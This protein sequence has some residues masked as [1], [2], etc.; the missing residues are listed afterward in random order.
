MTDLEGLAYF[1]D[2]NLDGKLNS[3]DPLWGDLK[4][5][6]DQNLNGVT[7]ANELR[8][9]SDYGIVDINLSFS[10]PNFNQDL[11]SNGGGIV[12][13]TVTSRKADGS[14][15]T[16]GDVVLGYA[17][18]NTGSDETRNFV[19]GTSS[20][21]VI[22]GS[23]H[24]DTLYGE[25]GND[26]LCGL[27]GNDTLMGG[28]GNDG[29]IGGGG[30]DALY[31]IN[32]NDTLIGED[33]NDTMM[34]GSDQDFLAGGDGNDS[35]I[36]D[37]GFDTLVGGIGDDVLFG[38]GHHDILSGEDGN[39]TLVGGWG[40]DTLFGGNHNDVLYGEDGYD[41]MD[42][43]TGDDNLFGGN[44]ND[45]L[46]GN[47]GNDT[48]SGEEG[49]D[50]LH[51]NDGNDVLYGNN[52]SDWLT[53]GAGADWLDGGNGA[54]YVNYNG[55]WGAVAVSLEAG[56]G[57]GAEAEG[58]R[59]FNIE[60]IQGSKFNDDLSGSGNSDSIWGG[61]G[62]DWLL[63][64][65]GADALD[66][67]DGYDVANYVESW[68]GVIIDLGAGTGTGGSAEGDRLYNIEGVHGSMYDD[69]LHGNAGSN[70]LF[71]AWGND[72]LHGHDGGDSLYGDLGD[73]FLNGGSGAD[74]LD[75]GEGY[76][77]ATY[78]WAYSGVGVSLDSGS[79][80]MGEATGDVY[81][82]IEG[83]VGSEHADGIYG[84]WQSN[85][86][87]GLSGNDTLFGQDGHDTI[88]GGGN[89][90]YIN[91]GG[92][93]DVLYGDDG[94][95]TLVGGWGEDYLNGGNHND[96]LYA[97][98]GNDTLVGG[99]GDD[100]L[101]GGN[102]NDELWGQEG[103]DVLYG[104][105]G[106]DVLVGGANE[107]YLHGGGH[108]DSL[109]GDD[110]YDTLVG[111]WG[112][113]YLYGGGHNDELHGQDGNDSINGG[114]GDDN[115]LGGEGN[116]WLVGEEGNDGIIG[117]GG[118]DTA[119]F[120]GSRNNHYVHYVSY[121]HGAIV[122]ATGRN[123]GDWVWDTERLWFDDAV[124]YFDGSQGW[125]PLVIDLDG[126]G[127]ELTDV[128]ESTVRF[129]MTGDGIADRTG[130]A[131][132]DDGLI[133]Y[134]LGG[135]RKIT[136]QAEVV[137][138]THGE[139]GMTDLEALAYAFDDNKDGWFDAN[140][141]HWKDFGV[142]QDRNQDGITDDGEFRTLEE[143]GIARIGLVGEVRAEVV[144]GNVINAVTRF[145]TVDGREGLIGDVTLY[146]KSGAE[147]ET[148]VFAA[149]DD[150]PELPSL[151]NALH[152]LTAAMAMF[153][154]QGE[155]RTEE[156]AMIVEDTVYVIDDDALP[157]AA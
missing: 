127:L 98:D 81:V 13:R 77:R 80:W 115:L 20:D 93:N 122:D 70:W 87:A 18:N 108:N 152:S 23:N 85:W 142:W 3:A 101:D 135:D 137:L 21:D 96:I 91:G 104:Q 141:A 66:G 113:D 26:T 153:D 138:A 86:F 58:D 71:G 106:N 38:G 83:V 78:Q 27:D 148:P 24:N 116:D 128:F 52:G 12:L 151:E 2:K 82:S 129:D 149:N 39:D 4:I 94:Y 79:G 56:M 29:L 46:F 19:V 40:E 22:F 1:F 114:W 150:V 143:V 9:L 25:D 30:N 88:F 10:E 49:D 140:D 44:H 105:D 67:G 7:D 145:E 121:G 8:R 64:R 74:R 144:A 134:D 157:K 120:A 51:G 62:D 28:N 125:P 50:H 102:H 147:E 109:Y 6:N 17:D 72:W 34:G 54:D 100:F 90:D 45:T 65:G 130:W 32:G 47:D 124:A 119:Y 131:A 118:Y 136:E 75:G 154:A 41:I 48:L 31:G 111:G 15:I 57:W 139:A 95:D 43:G 73:D 53:G 110:G 14:T 11:P 76:D 33:G 132:A 112:D 35:L 69:H 92:H 99:W 36:G 146:A 103:N 5:W 123:G 107:D 126:D 63:G 84:D 97:E 16:V 55:S 59:L 37:D 117:G 133:V 155:S 156:A 60:G 61:G 42:G 68:S 89:E